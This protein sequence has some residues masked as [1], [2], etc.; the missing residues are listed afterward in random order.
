ML[1]PEEK[2]ISRTWKT[3]VESVIQNRL[4]HAAKVATGP[5]DDIQGRGRALICVYTKDFSDE[6]DVRRVLEELVEL[7]LCPRQGS[8][9]YYK[10]DAFTHLGID[11]TNPYGLKASIYSSQEVLRV[12]NRNS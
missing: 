1:F 10:C 7:G 12:E 9:I 11:S 5:T 3:V 4:G 2:D 8:G 6:G